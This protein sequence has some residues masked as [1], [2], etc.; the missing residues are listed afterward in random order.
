MI[1]AVSKSGS[2]VLK[3]LGSTSEINYRKIARLMLYT[4]MCYHVMHCSKAEY[5][6]TACI[7][8]ALL[9]LGLGYTT[10]LIYM[11]PPISITPHP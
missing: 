7:A 8:A 4:T 10:R 3:L 11:Q 5:E 9:C 1:L 6:L 2:M